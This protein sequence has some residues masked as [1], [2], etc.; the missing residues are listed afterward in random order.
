MPVKLAVQCLHET[1]RFY[2]KLRYTKS[3]SD[4]H[5]KCGVNRESLGM[6]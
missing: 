2:T 3:E 6:F 5:I 1:N 4:S